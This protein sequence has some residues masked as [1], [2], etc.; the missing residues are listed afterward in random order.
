CW[1]E[2]LGYKCC[3]TGCKS[4]VI[5]TDENGSWSAENNEWCGVPASCSYYN[6]C[7]GLKLGY[8]CCNNC[9]IFDSDDSGDW[10]IENNEWCSIRPTC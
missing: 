8:K 9:L 1:S 7:P 6:G 2:P 3:S 10:G 5:Y 4:V